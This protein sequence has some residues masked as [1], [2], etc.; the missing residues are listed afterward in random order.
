[1]PAGQYGCNPVPPAT[2]C[3]RTWEQLAFPQ[4][5]NYPTLRFN[6]AGAAIR[7][8]LLDARF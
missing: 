6:Q 7:R 1:V 8:W 4:P 3:K 5:A 2:T